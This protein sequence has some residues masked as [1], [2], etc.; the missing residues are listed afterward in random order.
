MKTVIN[1]KTDKEVKE[2]AKKLAAEIGVPLSTVINAYL[3]E[4]IR[5][6]EIRFST[7]P[8]MSR[9]LERI[10]EQARKDYRQKR[11]VSKTFKSAKGAMEYL[12]A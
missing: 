7:V 3:K 4:F 1:I 9:G 11:N 10:V 5:N 8:R 12:D 2:R 6:R